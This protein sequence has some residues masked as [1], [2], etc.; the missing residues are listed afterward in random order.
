[1]NKAFNPFMP[2]GISHRY[3]LLHSISVLRDVRW[4]F[5]LYSS[6]NTKLCK[7]TGETLIRRRILWHLIW[8]CTI[9]L[10]PAERKLRIYGLKCNYFAYLIRIAEIW[11]V[12]CWNNLPSESAL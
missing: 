11:E 7:Q 12:H 2:N 4:Y 8:I 5:H 9:Y 10:C 1:M 6:F 3:Q